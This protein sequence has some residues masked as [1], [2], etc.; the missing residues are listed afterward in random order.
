MILQKVKLCDK[1][2]KKVTIELDV[3]ERY[4]VGFMEDQ[5][6]NGF[7]L[8]SS[9]PQKSE[10]N[11]IASKSLIKDYNAINGETVKGFFAQWGIEISYMQNEHEFVGTF[12]NCCLSVVSHG[13]GL[14]GDG[15]IKP[16]I[17]LTFCDKPNEYWRGY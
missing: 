5:T 16:S 3:I 8:Y 4:L 9:V 7:L 12:E 11:V 2:E 17:T 6:Y 1:A 10:P 14:L 15:S 13:N